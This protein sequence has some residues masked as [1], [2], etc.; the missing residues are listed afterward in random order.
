MNLHGSNLPNVTYVGSDTTSK[1]HPVTAKLK[2]NEAVDVMHLPKQ[3]L[4]K[5]NN[6]Q[7]RDEICSQ[8]AKHFHTLKYEKP[9]K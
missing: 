4:I 1:K 2:G 7:I 5:V 3:T 8:N 6:H 9:I